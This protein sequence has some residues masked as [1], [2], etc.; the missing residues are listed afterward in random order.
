MYSIT[1]KSSWMLAKDFQ[2]SDLVQS[3][4]A[5]MHWVNGYSHSQMLTENTLWFMGKAQVPCTVLSNPILVST[6]KINQDHH[7]RLTAKINIKDWPQDWQPHWGKC[8]S[9]DWPR[10]TPGLMPRVTQWHTFII[11]HIQC[12]SK[13]HKNTSVLQCYCC[14][15]WAG[16][17]LS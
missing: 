16:W 9:Q 8:Q 14:R 6:A 2:T 4:G 7:Q 11:I 10:S 15:G 17:M 5:C 3:Q 12:I 13:F 1:L